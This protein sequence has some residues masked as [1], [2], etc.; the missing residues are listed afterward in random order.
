MNFAQFEIETV[1]LELLRILQQDADYETNAG[2]LQTG[3]Q[4]R[5]YAHSADAV[6]TQCVWLQE[7]QLVTTRALVDQGS[8]IV[9]LTERGEDVALGRVRVPGVARPR[10]GS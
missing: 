9:K 3:L 7:Q 6:R 8:L 5:G 2:L 1:R 10:P 4:Y